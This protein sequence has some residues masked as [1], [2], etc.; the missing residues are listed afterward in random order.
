MDRDAVAIVAIFDS[1]VVQA[2][3]NAVVSRTI[4]RWRRFHGG[5]RFFHNH[6]VAH[7]ANYPARGARQLRGASTMGMSGMSGMSGLSGLVGSGTISRADIQSLYFDPQPTTGVYSITIGAQTTDGIGFDASAEDV[8]Q[9]LEALSNIGVGKVVVTGAG[10]VA[11]PFM[12]EFDASL[13]NVP[14]MQIFPSGNL[15]AETPGGDTGP[16][17]PTSGTSLG[18]WVDPHNV[19]E[20]DNNYATYVV[21]Q[22]GASDILEVRSF[23]FGTLPEKLAVDGFVVSIERAAESTDVIIDSVVA[24]SGNS[25][26]NSD[27]KASVNSW[28]SSDETENY[29]GSSDNWNYSWPQDSASLTNVGV[30]ISVQNNDPDFSRTASIDYVS[31]RL[32]YTTLVDSNAFIATVQEGA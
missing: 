23:D 7:P 6:P 16:V 8:Q 10:A 3:L 21:P 4:C 30:L 22:S 18:A 14:E 11:N 1:L 13:G 9:K 25:T 2:A 29:G 26:P 27:N 31:G 28:P 12:I 17:P 24:L 5:S 19:D 20:S 32:Y 15:F